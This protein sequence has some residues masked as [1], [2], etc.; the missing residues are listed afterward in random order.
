MRAQT[1]QKYSTA[2]RRFFRGCSLNRM[3]KRKVQK[4]RSK[5]KSYPPKLDR[6]LNSWD[7]I[8]KC[9]TQ[10]SYPSS[11]VESGRTSQKRTIVSRCLTD[12]TA[13]WAKFSMQRKLLLLLALKC[14]IRYSRGN[15]S[16]RI[17]LTE[18]LTMKLVARMAKNMITL[19]KA[20]TQ[21]RFVV[22]CARTMTRS[23]FSLLNV[24]PSCR[25]LG[26]TLGFPSTSKKYREAKITRWSHDR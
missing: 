18:E 6:Q 7:A 15:P 9:F 26:R 12:S 3:K 14:Q 2:N 10:M 13:R 24:T 4:A 25:Q 5:I 19:V 21:R 1:K 8:L 23:T 16:L 11:G 22:S 17:A 20:T